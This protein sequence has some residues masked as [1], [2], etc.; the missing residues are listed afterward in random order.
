MNTIKRLQEYLR[1]VEYNIVSS[2]GAL[3]EF[4][5]RE[6]RKTKNKIERLSLDSPAPKGQK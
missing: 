4:W 2:Q 1:K 3:Q 6:K 5:I